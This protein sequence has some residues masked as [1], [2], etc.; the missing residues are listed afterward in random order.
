VGIVYL[1]TSEILDRNFAIARSD[2]LGSA[3]ASRAAF[4]ALAKGFSELDLFGTFAFLKL[5]GEG[6]EK[7]T[8]GA[9]APQKSAYR[10]APAIC[11]RLCGLWITYQMPAAVMIIE[12]T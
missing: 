8:R 11:V 7:G 10:S 5:F 12:A 6:A 3:R 4:G 2:H 9:C 1:D